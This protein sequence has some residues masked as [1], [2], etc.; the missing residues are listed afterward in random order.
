MEK[1]KNRQSFVGW[2]HPP[3]LLCV[4][5]WGGLQ[6]RKRKNEGLLRSSLLSGS[7]FIYSGHIVALSPGISAQFGQIDTY[8]MGQNKEGWYNMKCKY[9][10]QALFTAHV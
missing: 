10:T 8:I 9:R 5:V 3:A 2:V 1:S 6:K 4:H 7:T